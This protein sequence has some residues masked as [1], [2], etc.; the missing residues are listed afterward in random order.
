LAAAALALLRAYALRVVWVQLTLDATIFV[1]GFAAFFWFLVL[2]PAA[3]SVQ[4]DLLKQALSLAYLSCDCVLVLMLGVLLITGAGLAGGRR[5]PPLPLAGLPTPLPP[6]IPWALAKL[7]GYYLSG[8]F[9][10]VLYM[11]CYVPL[12]AAGREQMRAMRAPAPET[13]PR[14]DAIAR[15]L[16]YAAMLAA[17]LMLVYLARGD[18]GGPATV[19]AMIV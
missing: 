6:R 1:V 13:A 18:I 12:A 8:G 5:V 4:V 2:R 15:A 16:P 14:S 10:D 7:R 11:M 3:M 9:Y 17:F 19:M